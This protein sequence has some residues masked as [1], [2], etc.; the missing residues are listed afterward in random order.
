VLRSENA[1]P[2][3]CR[4][5]YKVTVQAVLL[6]RSE[7]WILSPSSM[8][9]LEG[10]HIRAAW[11]MSSKLPGRNKD[12]SWTYPRSEDV[13]KAVG[14]KSIAH[15]VYV[16]RQTIAN[17]IVNQPILELCAGAVRKRGLPVQPFWCDQPMDL[18]L[19]WERG[20]RPLP[21]QGR[22]PVVIEEHKD[23]N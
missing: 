22:G 10:F 7:T 9:R 8:K 14:L 3:T 11:Q 23:T 18:N 16:G 19:V 12:G 17:F 2:K 15:Y 21:N 4:M 1:T 20:L 6:Y 13:L 5:F